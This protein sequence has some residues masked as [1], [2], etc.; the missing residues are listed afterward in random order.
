MA[1]GDDLGQRRASQIHSEQMKKKINLISPENILQNFSSFPFP[2]QLFK[3][4]NSFAF[5][6]E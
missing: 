5:S 1:A 3:I 6:T 4:F 2:N